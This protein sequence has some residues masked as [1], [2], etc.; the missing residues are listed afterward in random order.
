MVDDSQTHT[1]LAFVLLL[2]GCV[3]HGQ[4]RG[5]PLYPVDASGPLPLESGGEL[6]RGHLE[7]CRWATGASRTALRALAGLSPSEE[8]QPLGRSGLG[9]C[10][11]R[12]D[13]GAL[14]RD[15]HA[16]GLHCTFAFR[17][18]LEPVLGVRYPCW[19]RKSKHRM[20]NRLASSIRVGLVTMMLAQPILTRYPAATA[21]RTLNTAAR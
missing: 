19:S 11:E 3:G 17:R 18:A 16:R 13:T 6:V 4:V 7:E 15:E 21:A 9:Q 8:C 14:L 12:K 10:H 5:E 1:S 2:A 20:A